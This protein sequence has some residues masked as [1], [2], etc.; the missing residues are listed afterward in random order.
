MKNEIEKDRISVSDYSLMIS[1]LPNNTTD[2]EVNL[3]NR[4]NS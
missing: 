3:I 1:K 4:F 2:E